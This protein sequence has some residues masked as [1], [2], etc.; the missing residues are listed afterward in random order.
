[1]VAW[2][3]AVSQGCRFWFAPKPQSQKKKIREQKRIRNR[4]KWEIQPRHATSQR[5]TDIS[6]SH[7][8]VGASNLEG[9][10]LGKEPCGEGVKP[11]ELGS[12]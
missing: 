7:H 11:H 10:P 9:S 8:L 6:S 5:E 4:E 1:M 12:G 2:G 3:T